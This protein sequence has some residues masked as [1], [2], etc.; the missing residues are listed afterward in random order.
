MSAPPVSQKAFVRRDRL[1]R[2]AQEELLA[3]AATR[4]QNSRGR[5]TA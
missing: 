3:P 5:V 4:S 1:A 2:E